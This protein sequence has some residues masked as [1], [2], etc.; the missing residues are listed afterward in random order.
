[1]STTKLVRTSNERVGRTVSNASIAARSFDRGPTR[2]RF[3]VGLAS[4]CQSVLY[5]IVAFGGPVGF[6]ESSTARKFHDG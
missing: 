5:T 4:R 2:L 1:M 3:C 6:E